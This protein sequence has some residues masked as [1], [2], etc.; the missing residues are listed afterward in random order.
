MWTR[1]MQIRRSPV[2]LLLAALVLA[3]VALFVL[4]VTPAAGIS[5]LGP[6]LR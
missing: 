5:Q 1:L 2:M 3:G 4:A 6:L